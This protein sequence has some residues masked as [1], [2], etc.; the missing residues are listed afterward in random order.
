MKFYIKQKVF[1][2]KDKFS[3]TDENQN[4]IYQVKGKFMSI[5][6]KLELLDINENIL[7]RSNRK[8]LTFLAKYF[9]FDQNEEEVATIN[10]KL[11]FRP[12]FDLSILG[13]E[14]QLEGSLFQ[15]SFT[16]FNNGQSVAA[17]RKKIISWGDSYE[18]EIFESENI[19]LYLFVVIIL[20]Q[21]IHEKN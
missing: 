21:V 11:S 12:R 9:I 18:I 7:Y 13:R 8:V 15:H 20:D 14:M 2:F 3:I 17:I 19:E 6:N 4:P 10:R 5:T 16:I 1:T